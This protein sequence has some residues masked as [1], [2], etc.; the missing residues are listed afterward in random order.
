MFHFLVSKEI[1]K[2]SNS[3][4]LCSDLITLS[5]VKV[6]EENQHQLKA[7]KKKKKACLHVLICEHDSGSICCI[8]SHFKWEKQGTQQTWHR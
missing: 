3:R 8:R 4:S 2:Q 1:S 5:D 7:D 6:L